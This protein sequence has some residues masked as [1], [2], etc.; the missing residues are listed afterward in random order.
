MLAAAQA[1]LPRNRRRFWSRPLVAWMFFLQPI[2]RGW[3]R[4]KWRFTLRSGQKPATVE[5]SQVPIAGAIPETVTYWS[6]GTVDRF[7][8]LA[9]IL[10]KLEC[11]GC[12]YRA[13]TGWT[14]HDLEVIPRI[15]TRLR[16][17]TVS[18]DLEKGK[19]NF[20]CRIVASWSL[21]AKILLTL[22]TLA[23][24]LLLPPLVE[25]HPWA[26]MSLMLLPIVVWVIEDESLHQRKILAELV[27]AAANERSMVE[28]KQG[29]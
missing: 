25:L 20:R 23:L 28:L 8:F 27:K 5:V 1:K 21:P 22:T 4:F 24:I 18:E 14:S 29:Q 17:T 15:W 3:A 6:D 2:V 10:A 19:N 13:D 9:G 16:L 7:Q 26:W 11:A 12:M